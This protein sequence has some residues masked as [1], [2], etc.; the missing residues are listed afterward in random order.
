[1]WAITSYFNPARYKNRLSNFRVFRANLGVPLVTVELSFDGN[2]ELSEKDSDILIQV[3]GGAV[4]WQKE[5]L[6]NVA[7][8]CRIGHGTTVAFD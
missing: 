7:L 8:K 4:L 1:M 3:S 5:R 2:F 6:L